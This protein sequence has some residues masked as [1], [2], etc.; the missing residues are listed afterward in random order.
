[1]AVEPGFA[2]KVKS[3]VQATPIVIH[4]RPLLKG[5]HR[6]AT[7]FSQRPFQVLAT[8]SGDFHFVKRRPIEAFILAIQCEIQKV[9]VGED[10]KI[11][12]EPQPA[13]SGGQPIDLLSLG[14]HSDGQ[15][16]CDP[17]FRHSHAGKEVWPGSRDLKIGQQH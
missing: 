2:N 7:R 11:C 5:A 14:H 6:R 13:I 9:V 3:G 12:I 16:V 1:M 10:A 8:K 17:V 4:D 15:A